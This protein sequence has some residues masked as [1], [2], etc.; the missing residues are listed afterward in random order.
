M[1]A[2]NSELH[3]IDYDDGEPSPLCNPAAG[4]SC[5]MVVWLCAGETYRHDL[6][7]AAWRLMAAPAAAPI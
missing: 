2:E 5:L 7:E 6:S 3:K 1:L 4:S